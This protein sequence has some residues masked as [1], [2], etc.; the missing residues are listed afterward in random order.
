MITPGYILDD[1]NDTIGLTLDEV[2]SIVARY[3]AGEIL[4][5]GDEG[6]E[7]LH[8]WHGRSHERVYVTQGIMHVQLTADDL[9]ELRR[10]VGG[11]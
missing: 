8:L 11:V 3:D 7:D 6:T 2:R 9:A 4:T 10:I 5:W 1:G